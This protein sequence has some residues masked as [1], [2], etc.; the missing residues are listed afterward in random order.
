ITSATGA[1]RRS[2]PPYVSAGAEP[3]ARG[4]SE[5]RGRATDRAPGYRTGPTLSAP[6][7]KG[8]MHRDVAAEGRV[9]RAGMIDP[10]APTYRGCGSRR[11]APGSGDRAGRIPAAG[12]GGRPT[13][14]EPNMANPQIGA[15]RNIAFLR[16]LH[17]PTTH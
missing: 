3:S 6:R 11:A 4:R 10:L 9:A 16:G 8:G 13:V 12:A 1:L 17:T 2:C 15:E 14:I 7:A 5:M